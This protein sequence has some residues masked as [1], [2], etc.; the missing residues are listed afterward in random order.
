[1]NEMEKL[2]YDFIKEKYNNYR[3][4]YDDIT[5]ETIFLFQG[6]VN[7]INLCVEK[8]NCIVSD[9]FSNKCNEFLDEL[10]NE[11]VEEKHKKQL[12]SKNN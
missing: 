3:K 11:S 8:L 4:Q 12:D 1:M 2:V 6:V 9:E 7:G 10:I 5:M